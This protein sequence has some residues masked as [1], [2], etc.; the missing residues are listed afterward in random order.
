MYHEQ[1][2][3]LRKISAVKVTSKK[4]KSK[5]TATLQNKKG[6]EINTPSTHV[7]RI[8]EIE[9]F[10]LGGV[11]R[12]ARIFK[13]LTQEALAIK[14]GTTKHY[15]SRIEHN[16]SDIRLKTLMKIVQDGLGGILKFSVDFDN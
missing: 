10:N 16:G 13:N 3:N 1:K 12:E 11:I 5:K 4:S 9:S 7:K 2:S 8:M 15:I 14:S 6:S